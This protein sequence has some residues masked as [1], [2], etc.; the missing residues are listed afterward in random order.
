MR[1]LYVVRL[2]RD[3]FGGIFVMGGVEETSGIARALG[4]PSACAIWGWGLRYSHLF[5]V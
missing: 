4:G 3:M 2:S 5:V 1:F